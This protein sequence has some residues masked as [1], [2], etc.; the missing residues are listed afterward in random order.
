MKVRLNSK[1]RLSED[2]GV[3][4]SSLFRVQSL[5]LNWESITQIPQ[6]RKISKKTPDFLGFNPNIE[7]SIYES[8]GTT[9]PQTVE[10]VMSRALEQSKGYPKS[11]KGKFAIVSY[12]PTGGK[13]MPPF[14][15]VADPPISNIF[16]PEKDNSVL[17]HYTQVLKF[18]GFE[19]TV[20]AYERM[21]AEK[22][23]LEGQDQQEGTLFSLS[24]TLGLQSFQNQTRQAFDRERS[25]RETFAWEN[26]TYI[27]RYLDVVGTTN[28][29]FLGIY[30]ET[31]ERILSLNTN[32]VELVDVRVR[33]GDEEISIFSDGTIIQAAMSG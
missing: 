12:F 26:R 23:R 2:L 8:K 24:S 4:I 3:A 5:Q 19:S 18:V 29:L 28:R 17:L 15:F 30:L 21:L 13:S 16:I 31:I 10:K 14:T 1:K 7:R 9:Q 20:Q 27:G 33:D 32:I 6:N 25:T 22:F 11:A